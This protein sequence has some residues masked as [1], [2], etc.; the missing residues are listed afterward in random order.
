MRAPYRLCGLGLRQGHVHPN[1]THVHSGCD[2]TVTRIGIKVSVNTLKH[3]TH[4]PNR[5]S[6]QYSGGVRI[7]CP[8]SA[9]RSRER[10][11]RR[12]Y[13]RERLCDRHDR[14]GGGLHSYIT[15]VA[16]APAAPMQIICRPTDTTSPP[17]GN[18]RVAA[19]DSLYREASSA[20]VTRCGGQHS[21]RTQRS[22][23]RAYRRWSS[24]C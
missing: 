21:A 7:R 24:A 5:E 19:W 2:E 10:K 13:G 11:I 17:P 14:A 8:R 4:R 20:N 9:A 6:H 22:R 15:H 18:V 1:A 23:R 12:A 16:G 3:R